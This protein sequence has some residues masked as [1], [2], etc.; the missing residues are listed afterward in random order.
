MN[1]ES[2][3]YTNYQTWCVALWLA[4]HKPIWSYWHETARQ[5]AN[6]CQGLAIEETEDITSYNLEVRLKA[7]VTTVAL[8]QEHNL[9]SDLLADALH[10]VHW[11]E[12]TWDI[13]KGLEIDIPPETFSGWEPAFAAGTFSQSPDAWEVTRPER[14]AAL[15]R[16]VRGDWGLADSEQAVRSGHALL[17]GGAIVSLHQTETGK[18]FRLVTEQGTTRL[19]MVNENEVA[20]AS[21]IRAT[22]TVEKG[23]KRLAHEK[24][25]TVLK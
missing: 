23:P 2:N 12:I 3:G 4:V 11:G 7:E 16:H 25:T 24:K 8:L 17:H 21:G 9:Y 13:L 14:L 6:A 19:S 1:E 20:Q 18:L 22:L 10:Q 5:E 15:S